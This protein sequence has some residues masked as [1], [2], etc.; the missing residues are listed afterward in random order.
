MQIKNL[1]SIFIALILVLWG[2]SAAEAAS[3]YAAKVNGVGVE[4]EALEIAVNSYIENQKVMGVTIKEEDKGALEK[5]MLDQLIMVEL[6]YQE[7]KKIDLPDMK[8]EI[9]KQF[10]GIKKRFGSDKEFKKSL[11]DLGKTQKDLK[12]E[13][14]KGVHIDAFL[15]KELYSNIVVTE[16]EKKKEYKKNKDKFEVKEQIRAAHILISVSDKATKKQKKEAK[17]LAKELRKRAAGGED[18]A[19]LAR[20]NSYDTTT[21]RRG[22]DLGYFEK[23]AMVK[24]FEKAA[25]KL[26]KDQIS[27]V[28]ESDYGYH[29]IKL[30]DKREGRR[31]KYEEVASG[32]AR[33][34][35]SQKKNEELEKFVEKLKESAEIEILIK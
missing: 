32:I 20:Q 24:E 16:D 19:M 11:K 17:K 31:M 29:I 12:T 34:L 18:F 1:T 10:D 25:F 33:F 28:V 21:A 14:T 3:K 2:V 35:A 6:L 5:D 13:I 15:E 9:N 22:G 7:S 23:G 8:E 30:L 4:N 26:K 27:K